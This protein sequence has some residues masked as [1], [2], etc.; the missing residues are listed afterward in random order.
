[1]ANFSDVLKIKSGLRKREKFPMGHQHVT[2]TDPMLFGVCMVK[3]MS[4]QSKIDINVGAFARLARMPQP[5]YGRARLNMRA[6]FVPERVICDY[7]NSFINDTIYNSAT[8]NT[9]VPTM[10]PRLSSLDIAK[11][12]LTDASIVTSG[13]DYDIYSNALTGVPYVKYKLPYHNRQYLRLLNQLGYRPKF[14]FPVDASGNLIDSYKS[15]VPLLSLAKIYRD[16]YFPNQYVDQSNWSNDVE[17]L[18]QA[19]S[20]QDGYIIPY[21]ILRPLMAGL[22]YVCYDADFFT[23]MFDNPVGPNPNSYSSVNIVD[24]TLGSS[25]TSKSK[26]TESAQGTPFVMR[27]DSVSNTVTSFTQFINDALHRLTDYM[28]RNQLAGARALDRYLARYG[29]KLDA[30]KLKRSVYLGSSSIPLLVGDN[31]SMADTSGAGLGDYSGRGKMQGDP[32]HFEFET[33]EHGFF[34][35]CYSIVPEASCYQGDNPHV[36]MIT[37]LQHYTPEFDA[38][39]NKLAPR[40][41]VYSPL[42]PR[43][44]SGES[45]FDSFKDIDEKGFGFTPQYSE[46]KV[47]FD[48]VTGDYNLKSLSNAGFTSKGWHLMRDLELLGDDSNSFVHSLQFIRGLDVDQYLRIFSNTQAVCDHFDIHFLFDGNYYAPYKKLYDTYDFAEEGKEVIAHAQGVK[49]N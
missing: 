25:L 20:S 3:Y 13:D 43:N 9:F 36:D 2:T 38:L 23:S 49:M 31:Y 33:D 46:H 15:A 28:K 34:M 18:L 1:M 45:Y 26:V 37:K 42:R 48:Q 8:S 29:V 32:C 27:A 35:I 6:F 22:Q 41:W 7:F 39:G 19:C 44:A 11:V 24:S 17:L 21:Y 47:S 16:W 12:I 14:A 30:E 10:M 4:P 5:T 40:S